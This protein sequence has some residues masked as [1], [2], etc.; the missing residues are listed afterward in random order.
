MKFLKSFV[1]YITSTQR[2]II[3]APAST[4]VIL[5]EWTII[6]CAA[7]LYTAPVLLD[8][9]PFQLQQT[10]EHNESATRPL[11]AEIGLWQ[12]HEIPLWNHYMQTGFPHAGDL[13]GHFWS[14][15]A[16]LPVL[17]WGGINGMKVS[18]F[19]SFILAGLGQ[20]YLARVSGLK[21]IFRLWSALMFMFSGGLA[22]LWRLGWYEL[23]IGMAW[24]PWTFAAFWQALKKRDITSMAWAAFCAAMILLTGGGYYPFYL[25]ASVGSMF[26][27]ILIAAKPAERIIQIKRSVMISIFGFGLIAVMAFPIYDGYRLIIR[28][29]GED[30]EQQGSQ[31]LPYALMNYAISQPE[32]FNTDILGTAGGW[33]W[34]YTGSLML[35]ALIFLPLSFKYRKNSSILI[36]LLA[37]SIV[38]LL[39]VANRYTPVKYLYGWIKFLYQLRFPNRLLILTA[40]PLIIISAASLQALFASVRKR[41]G[42]YRL[43]FSYQNNP[44]VKNISMRGVIAAGFAVILFWGLRDV[45]K[46]NHLF[47]FMA[48]NLEPKSFQALRWLKKTDNSMYY[49]NLGGG[50]LYWSWTPAAYTVQIPVINFNYNQH[51]ANKYKQNQPEAPFIVLPK[52]QFSPSAE[53]LIGATLLK[54]FEGIGLWYFPD[55]L[56]FAFTAESK[57]VATGAKLVPEHITESIA[58]YD[59]PNRVIVKT[60][61]NHQGNV[62]VALVSN[63]PGW[64][65][66]RD[67]KPIQ[68]TPVNE[69]LGAPAIPGEH[70]YTFIFDPP[71]YKIGLI[72]TLST[73]IILLYFVSKE[74][75]G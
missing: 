63:Y 31:P 75:L 4:Y 19:I 25:I 5:F 57:E 53:P 56:P 15:V 70:T 49:V 71:L 3:T 74:Q 6:I 52:Y 7:Y 30:M 26:I 12:H 32:W 65:V 59:G 39:W 48:S 46:V 22:F 62:V 37:I 58:R 18:I 8:F 17:L 64:K 35:G 38:L 50:A 11:L 36:A 60:S 2:R 69:Y 68:L 55:T 28:E 45:Y 67:D 43:L 51:L 9:N 34:F 44:A 61:E 72:V 66:L 1:Q 23:L 27:V 24:F 73:I 16:T 10:G 14:P 33:N 47:G 40:S 29:S 21:G 42:T 54:D 13:L 20:W 41:F